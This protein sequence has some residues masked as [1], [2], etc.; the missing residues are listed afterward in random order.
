VLEF[1]DPP[2]ESFC[3]IA[4]VSFLNPDGPTTLLHSGSVFELYE[5]HR[6]VARGEVL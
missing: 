5:G 6:L 1:I 2:D 3:V 4:D